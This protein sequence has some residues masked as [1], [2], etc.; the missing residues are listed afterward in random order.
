MMSR[1]HVSL[2]SDIAMFQPL[3]IA[4]ISLFLAVNAQA[5]Q[6]STTVVGGPYKAVIMAGKGTQRV[7]GPGVSKAVFDADF[8][9]LTTSEREIVLSKGGVAPSVLPMPLDFAV[10]FAEAIQGAAVTCKE[11]DNGNV[12]G[13]RA[14]DTWSWSA[15]PISRA[16]KT[17]ARPMTLSIDTERSP[18]GEPCIIAF[19]GAGAFPKPFA[20]NLPPDQAQQLFEDLIRIED[21]AKTLDAFK[22]NTDGMLDGLQ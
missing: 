8:T 9:L 12:T 21:A 2:E 14:I 3:A 7:L 22:A 18:E 19:R 15:V 20:S 5:G 6:R 1:S 17:D 10:R 16:G 13:S 4:T 11:M